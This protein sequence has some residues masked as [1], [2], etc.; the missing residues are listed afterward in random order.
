MASI[1][2]IYQPDGNIQ[3]QNLNLIQLGKIV[4]LFG[5]I[6]NYSFE[7]LHNILQEYIYSKKR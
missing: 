2:N 1:H 3:C 5:G 7:N 6:L 4:S